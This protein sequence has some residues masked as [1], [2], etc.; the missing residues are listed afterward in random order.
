MNKNTIPRG[1]LGVFSVIILVLCAGAFWFYNIRSQAIHREAEEDLA[2]IAQMKVDQIAEWRRERLADA[3]VTMDRPFFQASIEQLIVKRN[4]GIIKEI[5]ERFKV[6]AHLYNYRDVFLV[7]TNGNILV[8]C[9]DQS[10]RIH[11][12]A[13][14][15]L[16]EAFSKRRAVLTE[17]HAGGESMPPH[18]SAVAPFF[19]KKDGVLIPLG[20]IFLQSDA[21]QFLYPLIRS[22]PTPSRSAEALIVRQEGDSVLYL[23]E[24]R[25]LKDTA[26][27]LRIALTEED[28]SAVRAVKGKEGIMYGKDYR[29]VKVIS[30]LHAIPDSPWFMIA[31]IDESEAFAVWR[32]QGVLIIGIMIFLIVAA[33]AAVLFIWQNNARVHFQNLLQAETTKRESEE[34]FKSVVEASLDAI[35]AV[36]D[37]GKVVLFNQSAEE[38]FQ[39][40][41][42][43]AINQPV[44]ILLRSETASQHQDRLEQFLDRGMGKCGHIGK[45][46]ERVFKRKDGT[47]FTAEV[48]MSGGRINGKRMISISIYDLTDRKQAEEA[49]RES[50]EMYRSLKENIPLGIYRSTPKG[51]ILSVNSNFAKM[52]GF[53]S[54]EE[55]LNVDGRDFYYNPEAREEF[56]N[57][58]IK[59]KSV[60]KFESL[61]QKKDGSLLWVSFN[62]YATLDENGEIIYFDG[63]A[64]DITERK[65]AEEAIVNKKNNTSAKIITV[66]EI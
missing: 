35:I 64:E 47:F 48:S 55:V 9:I 11:E 1:V 14:E 22:W 44:K 66:E 30:V 58:L 12:H 29:D 46:L 39:Y 36:D 54:V 21:E 51:K 45:R 32:M 5:T 62:A 33:F 16:K 7:D 65:R 57:R 4:T 42:E 3:A 40:S 37:K 26:L 18:I 8:S 34:R 49:L 15:A 56:L 53:D 27:K 23:N 24:L 38:L 60:S 25:H 43:E 13:I 28:V 52:Y 17:L 31:K 50:D 61:E 59:E 20:A 6:I 63:V 10:G 19:A 2:V 41:Q